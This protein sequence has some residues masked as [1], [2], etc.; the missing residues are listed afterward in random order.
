MVV[1][2]VNYYHFKIK[3]I[4]SSCCGTVGLLASLQHQDTSSIPGPVRRVK[5][6]S[7]GCSCVLDLI[8]CLGTPYATGWPKKFKKII[9]SHSV[10]M[11]VSEEF[12]W[13]LDA[14][15]RRGREVQEWQDASGSEWAQ[16][17]YGNWQAHV[18]NHLSL[19]SLRHSQFFRKIPSASPTHQHSEAGWAL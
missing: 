1:T 11:G 6:A 15:Q 9:F 17:L 5:G 2:I 7:P 16:W 10:Y 13:T 12:K 18:R 3:S 8:P 14:S 19:R 4:W